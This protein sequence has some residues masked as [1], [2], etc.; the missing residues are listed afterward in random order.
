MAIVLDEVGEKDIKLLHKYHYKYCRARLLSYLRLDDRCC[1]ASKTLLKAMN[2]HV[3]ACSEVS[4]GTKF[5]AIP[6]MQ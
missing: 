4:S 3:S 1:R 6:L 5:I 2:L